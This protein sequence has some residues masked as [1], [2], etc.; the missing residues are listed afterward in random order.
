MVAGQKVLITGGGGSIGRAL[1]PNFLDRDS[2]VIRVLD[3]N[4][5]DLAAIQ[6]TIDDKRCR[7]L[8][9]DVRDRD[10]L[11]RAMED[12]DIVVH[13]AAMKHVGISE[14]NPFESVKTNVL[15][16]Q[17]VIDAAIDAD[18]NK[19]VFTSSDKAVNPAN[20]MGTTKLLGEKL[21]TAGNKH[22]GR[23]DLFFTS[24][25][26]GNVIASSES[27]IPIFKDQIQKGGPVTIT[28]PEMTRFFLSY[29]DVVDLIIGAL[30]HAKG[31]EVF[32][33]KMNAIRI[34]DLADVMID[35]LAPQ[36]G[37][38]P[39]DIATKVI[40]RRVGETYHEHIMTTTEAKRTA[41]N[42]SMYAIMPETGQNGYLD[43]GGLEKFWEAEDITLSSENAQ[44][45]S[46]KE[47]KNLLQQTLGE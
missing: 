28:D 12:I 16:V 44:M 46:Q 9:G 25:R 24:V 7:F 6:R 2:E 23:E 34:E 22:K 40:G 4:E 45:L 15:G 47:V 39:S 8:L 38:N 11:D 37:Y 3:N 31:G 14:Y 33:K 1:I 17:N 18:V 36:Y 20:T 30:E 35:I 27:V 32:L 5:P 19:V 43:H 21:M 41:E 29:N 10:R 13:T 42:E 26:F